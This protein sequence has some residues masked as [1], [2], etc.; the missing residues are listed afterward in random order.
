MQLSPRLPQVQANRTASR[1]RSSFVADPIRRSENGAVEK[2]GAVTP[3][4]GTNKLGVSVARPARPR[5]RAPPGRALGS[6]T[7][8]P[9]PCVAGSQGAGAARPEPPRR[10]GARHG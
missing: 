7:G 2:T 1:V 4:Q 3:A 5:T 8:D 6:G 10:R 9:T